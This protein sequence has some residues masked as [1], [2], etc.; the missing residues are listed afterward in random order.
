MMMMMMTIDPGD[1]FGQKYGERKDDDRTL[2]VGFPRLTSRINLRS[3]WRLSLTFLN[4]VHK[5]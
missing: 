4:N 5:L 3:S 2:A 1:V